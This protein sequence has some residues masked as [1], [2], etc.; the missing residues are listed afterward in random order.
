[1][2]A[3]PAAGLP[4]STAVSEAGAAPPATGA[5]LMMDVAGCARGADGG[6]SDCESHQRSVDGWMGAEVTERPEAPCTSW[7]SV[8]GLLGG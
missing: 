2:V 1:V 5:N 8:L 4:A 6:N 3:V 7:L